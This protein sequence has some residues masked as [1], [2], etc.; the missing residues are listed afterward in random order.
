MP[1]EVA[2]PLGRRRQIAGRL[3]RG[4]PVVAAALA[5]EFGMS[6]DA[7]RR[8]LRA[9]AA[10]GL[11]RRVYGGALPVPAASAPLAE[12]LAEAGDRK[13]ALARRA[14]ALVERG[15]TLFLD[16]GSTTARIAAL[17]PAGLGLTVVTNSVPAAAALAGRDDLTLVLLGGRVNAAV[18]GCTDARAIAEL[19][20]FRFDRCFLGACA[21]SMMH[22]L[23]GFDMADVD[24]K[25]SLL[26]LGVPVALPMTTA[27][28]ETTAPFAIGRLGEIRELVLEPDA[29][30]PL[31]AALRTAGIAV[32]LADAP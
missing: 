5:A 15:Q 7:I 21:L 26:D 22:G 8:D 18:G 1:D 11:C 4:E 25:R 14:V 27:K 19:R 12:R 32:H 30:P 24:F 6:E 31:V 29:P 2:L 9:L 10:D 28:L 23:A 16:T 13:D 17:L 3:A 20:R